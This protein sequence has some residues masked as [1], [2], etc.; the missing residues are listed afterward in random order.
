[1]IIEFADDAVVITLLVYHRATYFEDKK[2]QGFRGQLLNCK[3][4]HPLNFLYTRYLE[5][6]VFVVDMVVKWLFG[7]TL[8]EKS[9][10]FYHRLLA[11]NIQGWNSS[12]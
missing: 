1:M 12:C 5:T 6:G 3:N 7:N 2:F 11:G 8:S 9:T 4:K 10:L